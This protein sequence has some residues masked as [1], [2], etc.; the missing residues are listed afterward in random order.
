MNMIWAQAFPF[1]ALQLF[2]GEETMK[3]NL[4]TFFV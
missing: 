2:E 4:A 3:S 1:V